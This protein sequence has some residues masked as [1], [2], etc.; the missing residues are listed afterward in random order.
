MQCDCQDICSCCA[1]LFVL[2]RL[3]CRLVGHIPC[4]GHGFGPRAQLLLGVI[5]PQVSLGAGMGLFAFHG[6]PDPTSCL[7][8]GSSELETLRAHREDVGPVSPHM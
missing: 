2:V 4:G 6:L 1:C 8:A 7:R 3:G 5:F